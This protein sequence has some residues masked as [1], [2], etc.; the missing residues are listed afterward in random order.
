MWLNTQLISE[1]HYF[2]LYWWIHATLSLWLIPC[3][4][5]SQACICDGRPKFFLFFILFPPATFLMQLLH[6]GTEE[7]G[8]VIVCNGPHT[9]TRLQVCVHKSI[10]NPSITKEQKQPYDCPAS[11]RV[12]LKY[13]MKMLQQGFSFSLIQNALIIWRPCSKSDPL[14]SEN[15]VKSRLFRKLPCRENAFNLY[16]LI[17][18]VFEKAGRETSNITLKFRHFVLTGWRKQ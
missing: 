11:K 5:C 12:P 4:K 1:Q 18:S 2:H 17:S 7:Q 13:K 8:F 16:T 3:P 10:N 9:C 15:K 6:W 14:H